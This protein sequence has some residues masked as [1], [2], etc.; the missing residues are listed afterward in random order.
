MKKVLNLQELINLQK[1]IESLVSNIQVEIITNNPVLID[2]KDSDIDVGELYR[3]YNTLLEQLN[4]I[5]LAK[6]KANRKRTKLGGVTNQALILE[7]SNLNRKSVLLDQLFNSKKQ[8]R[9]GKIAP[10]WKFQ[11]SKNEITDDI[12]TVNE[13]ISE[14][15]KSMTNFNKTTTVKVVIFDELNLL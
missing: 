3:E 2:S 5:K 1:T 4:I 10:A 14:I 9:K 13:R 11:I 6:D 7:L 12:D 8:N 15:K